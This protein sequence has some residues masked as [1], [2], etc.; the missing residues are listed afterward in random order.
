MESMVRYP[1]WTGLA[2]TNLNPHCSPKIVPEMDWQRWHIKCK[3]EARAR[4]KKVWLK[5]E[6]KLLNRST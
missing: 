3:F 5:D 2:R 4:M 1:L 6:S